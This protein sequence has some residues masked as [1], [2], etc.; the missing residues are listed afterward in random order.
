MT[1]KSEKSSEV[2]NTTAVTQQAVKP[3]QRAVRCQ[4]FL[5]Q[6]ETHHVVVN[7]SLCSLFLCKVNL[8]IRA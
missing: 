2:S 3:K 5:N 4:K 1:V 6:N 8:R 7:N